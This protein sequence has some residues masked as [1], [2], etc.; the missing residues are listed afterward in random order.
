MSPGSRRTV[1]C[2]TRG[3]SPLWAAIAIVG[4]PGA[5]AAQEAPL[6]PRFD[7]A[8]LWSVPSAQAYR[9]AIGVPMSTPPVND[10]G[11]AT[12]AGGYV[13]GTLI[14]LRVAGTSS[15]PPELGLWLGG[16][17]DGAL[18]PGPDGQLTG[19]RSGGVPGAS[20]RGNAESP[21]VHGIVRGFLNGLSLV[22][23]H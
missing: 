2:P 14:G 5:A 9:S 6:R 22:S 10:V 7:D 20:G 11:K 13:L 8:R 1:R 16:W 18:V 15:P 17:Y 3:L 19:P 23:S 12:L 4:C 21:L